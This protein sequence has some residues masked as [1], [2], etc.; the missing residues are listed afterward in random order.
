MLNVTLLRSMIGIPEK[1]R[2]VLRGMG[3][4]KINKT[5]QLQDTDCIRGMI[6]KVYHLVKFEEKTDEIK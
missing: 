5:V 1:H 3:L 2:S 4:T 6:R